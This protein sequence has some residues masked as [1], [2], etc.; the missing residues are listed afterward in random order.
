[1]KLYVNCLLLFLIANMI[2]ANSNNDCGR[3]NPS[4]SSDCVLSASDKKE[5]YIYC[6]YEVL[7]GEASCEAFTQVTYEIAQEI[8]ADFDA[9]MECNKSSSSTSLYFK[10]TILLFMLILF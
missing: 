2:N 7:D 9:K 8:A 1:M 4:K 5:N 6:C 10:F 3:I